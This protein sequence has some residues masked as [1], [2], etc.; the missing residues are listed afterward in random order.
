MAAIES[1]LYVAIGSWF[2]WGSG[3]RIFYFSIH[4]RCRS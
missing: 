4:L 1:E 3:R 2:S